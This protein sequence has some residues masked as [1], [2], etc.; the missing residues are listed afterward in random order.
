MFISIEFNHNA[1]P[2]GFGL[3]IWNW[4]KAWPYPCGNL[5]YNRIPSIRICLFPLLCRPGNRKSEAVLEEIVEDFRSNPF[6]CHN[7]SCKRLHDFARLQSQGQCQNQGEN[8]HV[9]SYHK[10]KDEKQNL[11]SEPNLGE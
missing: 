9:N 10:S 4:R 2:P 7:I 5:F 6:Y 3:W 8:H 1:K 11:G